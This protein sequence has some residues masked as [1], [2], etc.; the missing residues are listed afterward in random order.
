MK[1]EYN[2]VCECGHNWGCHNV[3]DDEQCHIMNC[4]CNSFS[5][6]KAPNS[7]KEKESDK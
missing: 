4:N 2:G 5:P 6:D 3:L 7:N 1:R